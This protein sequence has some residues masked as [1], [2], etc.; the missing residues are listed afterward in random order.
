[1]ITSQSHSVFSH[2]P[3][4]SKIVD[5]ASRRPVAQV[6]DTWHQPVIQRLEELVRL[7]L[8]WDGYEGSPVTFVNAVFALRML[9]STCGPWSLVPQIV[10]GSSG[11]LQVEWHTL[12]GDVEL[13]VKAPNDVHAWRSKTNGLEEEL[14]LT[15]DFSKIVAWIDELEEPSFAAKAAAA[16]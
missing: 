11:D 3:S 9:E 5:L 6:S 10:P 14:P 4:T 7:E 13:H 1:M 2:L 16:R 15:N 12:H 8:G